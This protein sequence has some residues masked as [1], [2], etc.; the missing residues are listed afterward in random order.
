M[1]GIISDQ[2]VSERIIGID[3]S[4][5]SAFQKMS[6]LDCKLLL[7]FDKD[8]FR[9]L[10]SSGDIQRAIFKGLS[11]SESVAS[12]MR[13]EQRFATTKNSS[14]EIEELMVKFRMELC[15]LVNEE[16]ELTSVVFWEDLFPTVKSMPNN[17]FDLPVIV[18]AGGQ[19]TRLR[20][21]TYVLPKPLIP[22]SDKS[23]LEEIFNRFSKF[24]SDRFF[25]SVN[26]K[27][28][29]IKYYIKQQQLPF[30]IE[31]IEEV[32]PLGTAGSLSLLRSEINE[33]FF[34]TNCDIL[35]EHDYS[36][37]L[38]FHKENQFEMTI[39]AATKNYNMPY[40]ILKVDSEGGLK[41]VKEKPEEISLVNSGMYILEPH[42]ISE[43]P[44]DVYFNLTDLID[45]LLA[46]GR[47]VGVFPVE[48]RSWKDVGNWTEFRLNAGI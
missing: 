7:V 39:V 38:S 16:G 26:Y 4:M 19:G 3:E 25:V 13:Q 30:K 15:P 10:L 23:M 32:K 21:L 18:M 2:R 41:S 36:E 12:L 20:P 8:E 1:K 43:I 47:K 5:S 46:K 9:G 29:L 35:I 11:L 45:K 31:Y 37:I 22:I 42:L 44:D 33:T 27:A 14:K 17:S 24:G 28:D 48:D 6:D 40:G 34:V